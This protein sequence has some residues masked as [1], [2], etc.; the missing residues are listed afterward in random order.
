MR[1]ISAAIVILAGCVSRKQEPAVPRSPAQV[2][3]APAGEHGAP[4]CNP[5]LTF[6][7]DISPLI[8][9]GKA[10]A[11]AQCHESYATREGIAA[12][13]K[14]VLE[15]VATGYM[16]EGNESFRNTPEGHLFLAWAA[17]DTL[18]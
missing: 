9:V 14:T 4:I 16:P 3:A 11:C 8:Q 17:C 1:M 15:A 7:R 5:K 2:Q 18:R 13:R 6:H 10:A 12:N